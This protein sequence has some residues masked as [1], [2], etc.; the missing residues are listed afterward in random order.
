MILLC[1]FDEYNINAKNM[2]VLLKRLVLGKNEK[3][4]NILNI[5]G[6]Y[7]MSMLLDSSRNIHA[8]RL[9]CNLLMGCE[10]VLTPGKLLKNIEKQYAYAFM[11]IDHYEYHNFGKTFTSFKFHISL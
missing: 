3:N 5:I 1:D 6:N 4:R 9:I 8:Y 2:Q 10:N 11:S 7:F